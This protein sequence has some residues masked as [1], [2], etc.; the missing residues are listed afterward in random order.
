M[1][2]INSDINSALLHPRKPGLWR[3]FR[4]WLSRIW[5]KFQPGPQ[6]RKG[7]ALGIITL[8]VLSAIVSGIFILPGFPGIL[9]ELGGAFILLVL[10]TLIGL[11][12]GIILKI[13][14][15]LP[16]F[17]TFTG[18]IAL[19]LFVFLM[20]EIQFP[21]ALLIG[22][23][24]GLAEAILGGQVARFFK[25][26]FGQQSLFKKIYVLVAILITVALNAYI[27]YWFVSTGSDD[28][29]VERK[30]ALVQVRP[31]EMPDPSLSGPYEVEYLT[32]GSGTDKR[33]PEFS[34]KAAIKTESVDA[35]A[36]VKGNEG[37]K[38]KFREWFWG[39][40]FEKF[41]RNGRVWYPEGAG[42]F[43]LVFC[44]HGNH[45]MAEFSDPGYAYLGEHLASRGFIFVSVDENFFNS[46]WI[47]G[48]KTE[49]D[50]RGWMLL[51]HLKLW[52]EWDR[53]ESN[54][55]FGKVDMDNIGLVGHSRGG[56][57]AAIG[58]SFN[59][60]SYYPDD[61]TVK[62]D[63][64]FNIKSIIAIAPSDGQY[65]PA[66]QP[67]PLENVNYM[68]IQ[69]AHDADVSVFVGARQYNRV[70]FTDGNYWFKTYIYS[71]R[72]NHGQF[73]TVWGDMDWGMPFSTILNRKALHSGEDQRKIGL[74]YIT[75]FLEAT[76]RGEKGYIPLFRDYRRIREWLPEDIYINRFED[77]TFR[78]VCHFDE[79]V[80]VTTA[81]LE[82]GRIK[83]ENLALWREAN[84]G[85]R[86][87][88][89]KDNNV[90]YVGWRRTE[91][92]NSQPEESEKDIPAYSILLPDDAQ[93][94]LGLNS[95]SLLI[96]SLADADEEP[97]EPEDK[98]KEKEKVEKGEKE[99]ATEKKMRKEK[100]KEEEEEEGK[101][102][103]F[104]IELLTVDGQ[105]A[106]LPLSRFRTVPPVL[107]SK[108]TKFG[109]ESKLYGK[110]YEPTLQVYELPLSEFVQEF[111]EFK[112]ASLRVIR[113]VFSRGS[114]GV[115]ILDRVG[116][117]QPSD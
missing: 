20:N 4:G 112:P 14:T 12:I 46:H 47:S 113:F 95:R 93:T 89:T 1:N 104:N 51:Q 64:G 8:I 67:T 40:D 84:L 3:R 91:P 26:R 73:N 107:K 76:L 44:V 117:A 2:E 34:K 87:K 22:L 7:A 38:M 28:H 92:E 68:T 15:V 98:D 114:K 109:K 54:P 85:F 108:F 77:S 101:P 83:G 24:L 75:A 82:G 105:R 86:D 70:K 43:P 63:F 106:K 52:R 69:G 5:Q 57:A 33:R 36:F 81:S 59:R 115:V 66:G 111:P 103:D 65:K 25:G 102:I 19:V 88:G 100:K 58:G 55:F 90:A 56:E 32:Y 110:A 74:I 11:L 45:N 53:T 78:P 99:K 48:L 21:N 39:F 49:N 30:A 23:V 62:F 31:L 35:T 79:D 9:D 29:L 72:S 10:A 27:I 50:G 60:L 18:L 96:F 94:E 17:I 116:F 61:A 37:W 80:D 71:Y 41:P 42:P 97:P 13:L 6:V 16:R